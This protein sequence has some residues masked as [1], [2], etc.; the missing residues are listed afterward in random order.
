MKVL[1]FAESRTLSG[2][3]DFVLPTEL[4]VTEPEF[5]ALLLKAFP[6]LASL[7]KSA[8]LARNHSYVTGGELLLPQDEIAVIPPVSGG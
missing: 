4:P 8:R 7:R 6:L 2:C 3:D 5:W 1:F